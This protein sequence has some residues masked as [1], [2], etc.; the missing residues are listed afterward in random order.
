MEIINGSVPNGNNATCWI[1]GT[2]FGAVFTANT[3][4][5]NISSY[6]VNFGSG[7]VRL[8]DA[9][10]ASGNKPIDMATTADGTV[11]AFRISPYSFLKDLGK[12]AGLPFLFAQGIAVR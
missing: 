11:S 10:A 8:K 3:A 9:E 4:S 1:T 2:W 7:N 5:D 6:K 12:V